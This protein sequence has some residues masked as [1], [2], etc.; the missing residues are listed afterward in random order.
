[1]ALAASAEINTGVETASFSYG[2]EIEDGEQRLLKIIENILN[3][4][5]RGSLSFPGRAQDDIVSAEL[6]SAARSIDE[7]TNPA[8]II[9]QEGV[10]SSHRK[11]TVSQARHR[12]FNALRRAEERRLKAVAEEARFLT[13]LIENTL[14]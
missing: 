7:C 6:V 2:M 10:S 4:I 9:L 14:D 12:A 11:L 8:I 1:M 3:R 13:H 5:S